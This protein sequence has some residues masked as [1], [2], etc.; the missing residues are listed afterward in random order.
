MSL[1][2]GRED[3]RRIIRVLTKLEVLLNH[4]GRIRPLMP[5]P[6]RLVIRYR[7]VDAIGEVVVSLSQYP[8][9]GLNL[10]D[11]GIR[12]GGT[13]ALDGLSHDVNAVVGRQGKAGRRAVELSAVGCVHIL[14]DVIVIVGRQAYAQVSAVVAIRHVIPIFGING[15]L[16]S[17]ANCIFRWG[18]TD[19]GHLLLD[20]VTGFTGDQHHDSVRRA[21]A[22]LNAGQHGQEVFGA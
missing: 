12:V 4:Y 20:I 17:H 14:G 19:F 5:H 3:H 11:D 2:S 7:V 18:Q 22:F 10:G 13:G 6:G 16:V 15:D 9:G 8:V 21:V 1:E